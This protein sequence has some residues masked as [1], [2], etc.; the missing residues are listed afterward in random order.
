MQESKSQPQVASFPGSRKVYVQGSRSDLQVPMREIA[1]APTQGRTGEEANEP[2][3]VYDT[4]GPYTD[5]N[6]ETDI[7]R[8]L[9]LLRRNWIIERDDVE[10]YEG[11]HVQ[12]IDDGIRGDAESEKLAN[13]DV[14]PVERKPLRA[15]QGRT[16]TQL[17]Y[18]RQGIV[19]PEM[20]FIA[21]REGLEPEFVRQEVASGRA[22]IPSNINHPES[23][24]M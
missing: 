8:G 13:R 22:I 18:A 5:Q 1:L 14:F 16:V 6:V 19:T 4:S 7:R 24:P 10:E 20:E 21:I 12:L 3:R 23:E 9:P 11:R 2:V 17:H 15:K